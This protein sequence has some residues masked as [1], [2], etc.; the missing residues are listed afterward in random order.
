MDL[1]IENMVQWN[2]W[3]T[4]LYY[5][6]EIL[7]VKIVNQLYILNSK[8]SAILYEWIYLIGLQPS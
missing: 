8:Y 1:I 7:L 6:L 2:T 4:D 5:F 3:F